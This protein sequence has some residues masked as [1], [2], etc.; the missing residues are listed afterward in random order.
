MIALAIPFAA[1]AQDKPVQINFGGGVS[2]PV[3]DVGNSFD[4]GW[5]FAAGLTFNTNEVVGLQAEYQFH[6]FNGPERVFNNVA[7]SPGTDRILIES[8]QQMNVVDFNVV[9]RA[10][11]TSGV[12]GY[13]LAGP[14]I[15]WRK[16]QLTTPSTGIIT[17]CDPYWYVCYPT[18]VATDAIV[19]D[20]TAT[21]FG[22]NVGGGVNFGAF[23]VE[24]RYHYVFG[25]DIQAPG[26]QTY[27][28][29]AS[30]FPITV[31]FRF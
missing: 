2:F 10:G 25:E 20:R 19:G 31:G 5:N 14:G 29:K 3:G 26:G 1:Q 13:L 11:G 4:T 30:Y 6:R 15:Y 12:R 22:V 21:D 18:P 7:P 16:V 8:N 27:S 28:T 24:A 17:V 9:L 23:Y